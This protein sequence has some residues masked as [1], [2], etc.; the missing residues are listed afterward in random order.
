MSKTI[1]KLEKEIELMEMQYGMDTH[2]VRRAH[3]HV[4]DSFL[5]L[6]ALRMELRELQEHERRWRAILGPN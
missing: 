2:A 3:E 6:T 5:K 1:K 4:E